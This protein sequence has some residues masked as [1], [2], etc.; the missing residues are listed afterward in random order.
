MRFRRRFMPWLAATM[1]GAFAAG[2]L[3]GLLLEG[4][5]QR[6]V[7]GVAMLAWLVAAFLVFER[8]VI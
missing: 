8:W 5:A 7:L 3:P 4:L 6:V 2:Y 1:T